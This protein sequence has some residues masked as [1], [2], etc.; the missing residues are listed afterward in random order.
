MSD[1]NHSDNVRPIDRAKEA[2][3][4]SREVA[5]E[6][7]GEAGE[8]LKGAA[9]QVGER[10]R[11]VSDQARNRTAELGAEA[12]RQAAQVRERAREQYGDRIVQLQDG[13]EQVRERAETAG[14]DLNDYVRHHPGKSVLIAA[15]AGFVLGLLF[16]SRD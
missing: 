7:L 2:V 5:K 9:G 14:D 15:A 1:D 16:R 6:Q 11:D 3:S 10:L 4:R 12:R 13:Y 8:R